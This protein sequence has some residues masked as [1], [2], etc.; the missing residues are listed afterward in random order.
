MG[1]GKVHLVGAQKLWRLGMGGMCVRRRGPRGW[2]WEFP[3]L[4]SCSRRHNGLHPEGGGGNP[5]VGGTGVVQGTGGVMGSKDSCGTFR[6]SQVS[7]LDMK[8]R[9]IRRKTVPRLHGSEKGTDRVSGQG[10]CP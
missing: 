1:R 4:V 7:T 3:S 2:S 8:E 10:L 5:V 9:D 6:D